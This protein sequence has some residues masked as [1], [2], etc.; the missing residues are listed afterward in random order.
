MSV[1]ECD[2]HSNVARTWH[3][4]VS[5]LTS[6]E[7]QSYLAKVHKVSLLGLEFSHLKNQAEK[8]KESQN[9]EFPNFWMTP[10]PTQCGRNWESRN[11]FPNFWI[12]P[13]P[14]PVKKKLVQCEILNSLV[15]RLPRPPFLAQIKLGLEKSVS[16]F[17]GS[18]FPACVNLNGKSPRLQTLVP[19]YEPHVPQ[20]GFAFLP[21]HKCSVISFARF[22]CE[23]LPLEIQYGL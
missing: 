21:L 19:S 11:G 10:T 22:F 20:L 5:G 12:S 3:R 4:W 23:L 8:K 14:P 13:L 6:V 18:I 15:S 9:S 2:T 7:F 16:D 1:S 17:T